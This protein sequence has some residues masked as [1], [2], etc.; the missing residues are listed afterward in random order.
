MKNRTYYADKAVIFLRIF[1]VLEVI[2][3][4]ILIIYGAINLD[5]HGEGYLIAGISAVGGGLLIYF[6]GM[7]LL[8]M[9]VNIGDLTD[10]T[11]ND[12]SA[13]IKQDNQNNWNE[14]VPKL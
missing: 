5:W 10:H 13:G 4:M 9:A 2:G 6:C 7:V 8:E 14:N 1:L 11:L 12:S 3:S